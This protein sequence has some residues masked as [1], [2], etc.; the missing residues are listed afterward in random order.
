MLWVVIALKELVSICSS[1]FIHSSYSECALFLNTVLKIRN[2]VV[3]N[4]TWFSGYEVFN[5]STQISRNT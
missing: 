4:E 1:V 2:V 3:N 5:L